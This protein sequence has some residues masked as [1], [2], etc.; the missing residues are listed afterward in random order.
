[1]HASPCT[2]RIHTDDRLLDRLAIA[3]AYGTLA[4]SLWRGGP[5]TVA[6]RAGRPRRNR[7]PAPSRAVRSES[8]GSAETPRRAAAPA[9]AVPQY[10]ALRDAGCRSDYGF[11]RPLDRYRR[12]V[13]RGGDQRAHRLF[14]GRQG[15]SCAGCH[16]RHAFAA[17]HCDPRRQ[18]T[19]DRCRRA[20]A[21]RSCPAHL[22]RS[23][24]GGFAPDLGKGTARRGSR[25]D[26]G[27]SAIRK[28][29]CGGRG[30]RAAGRPLR[31]GL[32]GHARRP[33]PGQRH[34]RRHRQR[35]RT[36]QDQP[37]AR[38]HPE[39]D[40]AAAAPDRPFRPHPGAGDSGHGR[41][42]LPA[43]YAVARSCRRRNVHDGRGPGGFGHSGGAAGDHDGHARPRDPAHGAA[44][45]NH[46]APAGRR[47]PG[48]GHG[49]L[50]RQDRHPDAQRND[51][52]TRGLRRPRV[53]RWRHRLCASRRFQHRR[54][55]HR[56]RA[57]S[58]PDPGGPCQRAVQ[59]CPPAPG[60][61]IVVDRRRSHR[62]RFARSRR[63]GW[64]H[65][66]CRRCGLSRL[67]RHHRPAA[68]GG[69]PCRGRMPSRRHP[70]QDDHRRSPRNGACHRCAA[71]LPSA[72]ASRPSPAPRSRR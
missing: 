48:F 34:C 57:L 38:R 60:R 71:S 1:M 66:A 35:H 9:D 54:A 27:I 10:P 5:A 65:P 16:T 21:G 70:H 68:R 36:G 72:S 19:R 55:H 29:G 26:R 3:C 14:P 32:F 22:R 25:L 50:F 67:R 43:R 28:D 63:Q 17:C 39:P 41:R 44:Q 53:R 8:A 33:W 61:G 52:S 7:G 62:G 37:H 12:A 42:D 2:R 13:R 4:H 59:R 18:P 20:G 64:F 24:S 47:D 11:S 31:H 15:R 69:D 58:C 56:H 45:C 23:R 30:R 46:P 49:D 40:H 51:R 6:D